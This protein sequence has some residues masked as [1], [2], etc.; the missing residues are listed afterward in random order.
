MNNTTWDFETEEVRRFV[1]T[2]GQVGD[3]DEYT[4]GALTLA[5]TMLRPVELYD[6]AHI[7]GDALVVIASKAGS[8]SVSERTV[9][10]AASARHIL[11]EGGVGMALHRMGIRTLHELRIGLASDG[12]PHLEEIR[13]ATV[14]AAVSAATT[15]QLKR[16]VFVYAG[17]VNVPAV[18]GDL[19]AVATF[20]DRGV[21]RAGYVLS[22]DELAQ[23][24]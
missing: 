21:T 2:I 13:E 5:T 6:H 23:A 10:V 16:A 9:P 11:G 14:A 20:L 1:D 24:A 8:I 12:M 18:D 19:R 4:I 3:C 22:T 7:E 17:L 15:P